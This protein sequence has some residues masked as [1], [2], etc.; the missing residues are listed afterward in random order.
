MDT[1]VISSRNKATLSTKISD[2]IEQ[3]AQV[4]RTLYWD[5]LK[6]EGISPIQFQMMRYLCQNEQSNI[7]IGDLVGR[8]EVSYATISD[9]I[10]IL[11]KKHIVVKIQD[12]ADKRIIHVTLSEKGKSLLQ[13]LSNWDDKLINSL[14]S[15]S[16]ETLI[17]VHSG[18]L[19]T[20]ASLQNNALLT[21][22]TH[23]LSCKHFRINPAG[24]S[25][26]NHYCASFE[27]K[28]DQVDLR[29]SCDHHEELILD[30]EPINKSEIA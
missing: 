17:D 19:Q 6:S 20:I 26:D 10:K 25:H 16:I 12:P 24:I 28:L 21:K 29:I 11:E 18:I 13:S 23:C 1:L 2:G 5:R 8:F 14:S 7:T 4:V 27:T 30:T 9:S 3:L 22:S 15:L